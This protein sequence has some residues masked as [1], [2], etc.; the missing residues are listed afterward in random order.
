M[1]DWQLSFLFYFFWQANI[2]HIPHGYPLGSWTREW[3]SPL[4]KKTWMHSY[5]MTKVPK[6]N[7]ICTSLLSHC[8]L[9]KLFNT[10]WILYTV[11][12]HL[13]LQGNTNTVDFTAILGGRTHRLYWTHVENKIWIISYKVPI[14][15]NKNKHEHLDEVN[16]SS[17]SF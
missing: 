9:G 3:V 5:K 2:R 4:S 12:S 17:K 10:Y 11:R 7:T 1:E 16:I 6:Q 15:T 13:G 8:R 14:Q